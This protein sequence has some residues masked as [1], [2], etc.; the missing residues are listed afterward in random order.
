MTL[1]SYTTPSGAAQVAMKA[2]ADARDVLTVIGLALSADN[3]LFGASD[4]E[5]LRT[6]VSIGEALAAE[7]HRAADHVGLLTAKAVRS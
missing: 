3:D 5:A 6:V 7:A 2:A 4:R 1:D